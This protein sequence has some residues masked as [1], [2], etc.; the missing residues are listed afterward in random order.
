KAAAGDCAGDFEGSAAGDP[1]RSHV[2]PR[3]RV[4]APDSGSAAAP[5]RWTDL[6]CDCASAVDRAGGRRDSRVRWR[7]APGPGPPPGAR[8]SG[9][10]IRATVPAA[11]HERSRRVAR[12]RAAVGRRL[13][14]F[15]RPSVR[16]ITDVLARR[17]PPF[18]GVLEEWRCGVYGGAE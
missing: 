3:Q 9:R 2:E 4:R 15:R 7:A 1:R 11:V 12:A 6:V 18:G 13:S 16:T 10:S 5:L 17:G 14:G 8:G